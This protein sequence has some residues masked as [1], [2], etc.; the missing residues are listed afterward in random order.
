MVDDADGIKPKTPHRWQP[1]QSG[2]PSGRPKLPPDVR[3]AAQAHTIEA[4]ATLYDV[5]KNSS[6]DNDRVSAATALL[7][8]AHGKPAQSL[9]V[10]THD[11]GADEV[12][13]TLARLQADP[14]SAAALLTLA[15]ASSRA[16]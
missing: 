11:D 5:M 14:L 8:R 13:A 10:T 2:N 15:E 7:D 6:R 1:G 12:R 3:A 4:I 16:D 9:D